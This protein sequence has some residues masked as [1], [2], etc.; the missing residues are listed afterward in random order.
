MRR[1]TSLEGCLK[2]NTKSL[3][4]LCAAVF[5]R[6][7]ADRT[8]YGKLCDLVTAA[9]E[10]RYIDT[11]LVSAKKELERQAICNAE[12]VRKGRAML[13][14]ARRLKA[15]RQRMHTI[16]RFQV[17]IIEQKVMQTATASLNRQLHPKWRTPR[18]AFG[19]PSGVTSATGHQNCKF[20]AR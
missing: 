13:L 15:K 3:C 2:R 9:E 7:G 10:M 19:M 4:E 17:D 12:V 16:W 14:A 11:L 6:L 8:N 20:V 18:S 1:V 5:P